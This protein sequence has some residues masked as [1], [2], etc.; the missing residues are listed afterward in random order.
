[1]KL[2]YWVKRLLGL[3]PPSKDSAFR[4]VYDL[5]DADEEYKGK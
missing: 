4:L 1:M 2:K 3:W 5:K